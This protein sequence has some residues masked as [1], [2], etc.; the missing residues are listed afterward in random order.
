M[1]RLFK[2]SIVG[3]VCLALVGCHRDHIKGDGKIISQYRALTAFSELNLLGN[4]MVTVNADQSTDNMEIKTDENIQPYLE[5][6]LKGGALTIKVKKGYQIEPTAPIQIVINNKTIK[7]VNLDGKNIITLT[8]LSGDAFTLNIKGSG[9][10]VL[11][12]SLN[13][14]FYNISGSSSVNAANLESHEVKVKI[15]GD[16]KVI[17]N[18]K[19]KLDVYINGAGQVTYF[20]QPPIVNREIYG[21]GKILQGD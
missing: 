9:A 19:K 15:L 12:G 16:A 20:G 18:V 17:I 13:N 6:E 21:T 2:Y 3:V 10:A 14:A 7:R 8:G 11:K 1:K 4:Y 5:S